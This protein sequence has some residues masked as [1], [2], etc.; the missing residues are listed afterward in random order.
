MGTAQMT[1]VLDELEL[2]E[3]LPPSAACPPLASRF[4]SRWWPGR[5]C[6]PS[7]GSTVNDDDAQR[8]GKWD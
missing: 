8:C 2:T 3:L 1:I 5:I 6:D 7:A 4:R